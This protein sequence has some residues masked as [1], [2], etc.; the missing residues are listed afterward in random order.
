MLRHNYKDWHDHDFLSY[1]KMCHA[2][3]RRQIPATPRWTTCKSNHD[4]PVKFR[5]PIFNPGRGVI[6]LAD[7]YCKPN[8]ENF[9]PLIRVLVATL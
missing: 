7:A 8:L 2:S 5:N 9:L 1:W 6:K 4:P 3:P